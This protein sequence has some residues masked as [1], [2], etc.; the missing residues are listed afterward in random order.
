MLYSFL[1][2]FRVKV[3]KN[4][5]SEILGDIWMQQGHTGGHPE[6]PSLVAWLSWS[7]RSSSCPSV[8]TLPRCPLRL[9]QG[10]AWYTVMRRALQVKLTP[11]AQLRDHQPREAAAGRGRTWPWEA[12]SS[13][14]RAGI[15]PPEKPACAGGGTFTNRQRVRNDGK[16]PRG[17]VTQS[18]QS[19]TPLS[20][21]AALQV[22]YLLILVLRL[23]ITPSV[24]SASSLCHPRLQCRTSPATLLSRGLQPAR[25][26][27]CPALS[28]GCQRGGQPVP[29]G[30][31]SLSAGPHRYRPREQRTHDLARTLASP[32]GGPAGIPGP[33]SCP[34]GGGHCW[35][36][37]R[38]GLRGGLLP[39]GRGASSFCS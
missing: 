26:R 23:D 20:C 33:C 2:I 3:F 36:L 22:W 12:A 34:G 5:L 25:S 28:T 4:L 39:L 37:G 29:L 13:E 35:L 7:P 1:G 32:Q 11:G 19:I 14:E 24:P 17:P 27:G 21:G 38:L 8:W 6:S 18:P 30:T 10:E 9:A 15:C 16:G 31:L